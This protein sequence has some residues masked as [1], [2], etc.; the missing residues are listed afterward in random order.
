VNAPPA[1]IETRVT[2]LTTAAD[3]SAASPPAGQQY[4]IRHGGHRAIVCEVGATLRSYSVRDVDIVDGFAVDEMSPSGRGQVLAPWPNRLDGGRYA[5]AGREGH[6]AL[7]EPEAGN[8]IHGLV[9]WLPWRAT[10][11]DEDAITMACTLPPQPGYPWRLLL[12]VDYR[13]GDDGLTVMIRATNPS[14]A[15]APFGVGFHPYVTVGTPTI[16]EAI[17]E[18]PASLRLVSDD[19]GLPTGERLAVDGTPFDF[20]SAR[21]LGTT[22]LDTAYTGLVANGDGRVWVTVSAPDGTRAVVVWADRAFRH[23]MVYTGDTLQPTDRRRQS[24][25]VEPMTC[26]P[27]ALRIGDDVVRLESGATWSGSWGINPTFDTN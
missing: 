22:R 23:F 5:F 17:V 19:R 12:E 27:N 2:P 20:R 11:R 10:S 8:A 26:P 18:I 1:E 9:R 13:V 15:P 3:E 14:D 16:D 6:A 24:I 7:D 4:E 21:P 25:A